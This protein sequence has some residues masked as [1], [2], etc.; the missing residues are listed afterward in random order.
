MNM[1]RRCRALDC[2]QFTQD[3]CLDF[4]FD[5][6]ISLDLPTWLTC[7]T[8]ASG[9]CLNAVDVVVGGELSLR[10][11]PKENCKMR[12]D[13]VLID[14]HFILAKHCKRKV[15]LTLVTNHCQREKSAE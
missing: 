10:L 9:Q 12:R 2:A 13:A 1:I 14:D 4:F 5:M 7:L 6:A 15:E 11:I 8:V 3:L